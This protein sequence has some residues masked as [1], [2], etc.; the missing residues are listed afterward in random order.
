MHDLSKAPKPVLAFVQPIAAQIWNQKY[1]YTRNGHVIDTSLEDTWARVANGLAAAEAQ[2][3][4]AWASA[5]FMMR[6]ANSKF[7][8]Q[9]E[10]WRDAGR[11]ATSPCPIHS[12]CAQFLIPYQALW[13][14]SKTPHLRC[15]WAAVLGSISRPSAP[16]AHG[17]RVLIVPQR[18][19][20]RRWI[21]ST[22]PAKWW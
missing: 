13:I 19:P 4:Q 5:T 17:L 21:F 16:L 8:Q 9:G 2:S 11:R 18:A 22:R 1:R 15:K 7:C 3:E 10:F 20:C 6:C 14:P 12:L